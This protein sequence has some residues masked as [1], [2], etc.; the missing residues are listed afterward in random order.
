MISAELADEPNSATGN[1]KQNPPR[2]KSRDTYDVIS[3]DSSE[4]IHGVECRVCLLKHVSLH[5]VF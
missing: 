3:H 4:E 2:V 1:S 5:H